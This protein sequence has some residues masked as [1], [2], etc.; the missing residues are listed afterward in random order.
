[1]FASEAELRMSLRLSLEPS[2][3]DGLP[4]RKGRRVAWFEDASGLIRPDLTSHQLR[5]LNLALA[6][7]IGAETLVWLTDVAGLSREQAAEQLLRMARTLIEAA[8][9]PRG[10]PAHRQRGRR[11]SRSPPRRSP[12][13]FISPAQRAPFGRWSAP[14]SSRESRGAGPAFCV[15]ELS[16]WQRRRG[17]RVSCDR[18]ERGCFH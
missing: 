16:K 10:E 5:R 12:A 8:T 4:L 7:S 3:S 13:S 11:R 15:P 6:A 2:E 18:G 17:V 9:A 1:M 14:A